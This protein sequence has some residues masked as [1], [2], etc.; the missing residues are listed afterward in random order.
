[1]V[2]SPA[3]R[4]P[5][6]AAFLDAHYDGGPF[7]IE[8]AFATNGQRMAFLARGTQ[9][10]YVVKVSDP[11]RR[12]TTVA[13]DTR[14]QAYLAGVG[15]P[16]PRPQ[17]ARS[18]ALYLPY[19]ALPGEGRFLYLYD[20]IPGGPP[21]PADRFY[22]RLGQMLAQLHSLPWEGLAPISPYRP[23]VELPLVRER[24]AGLD[25]SAQAE[26]IADLL[27]IIDAF[28]SFADLPT[29]IIHTDPYFVNLLETPAG[30]LYLI[31]WD[32][33]GASYP[34]LD[35]GYV[36]AHLC[37]FTARDRAL[38]GVPGAPDGL[39]AR[40][41]WAQLFLDAYQSVR[42]LSAA[43]IRRLPDAVRISFLVYVVDWG[44]RRLIPENYQH[45][46]LVEQTFGL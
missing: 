45:M 37:S 14:T 23:E 46:K 32:D 8:R 43:E 38:W 20:Y 36:L 19:D 39:L 31:D 22:R 6:L 21:Q 41:D 11:D 40:P 30:G 12:E 44:T 5:G 9:A 15:F 10:R 24:L 42:P 29:G 4:L 13:T 18:G 1:M 33:A 26:V 7:Q 34:L 16:A 17:P 27:E 2:E 25:D 28:P 35:V 3:D